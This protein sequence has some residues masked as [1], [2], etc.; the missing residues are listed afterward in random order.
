MARAQGPTIDLL[1]TDAYRISRDKLSPRI[2]RSVRWAELDIA[3]D[4]YHLFQRRRLSDGSM[5]DYTAADDGQL[6][7]Y[8]VLS[9][10]TVELIDVYDFRLIRL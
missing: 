9:S 6:I 1:P 2:R 5:I 8:R 7:R 3:D 10:T 4:P